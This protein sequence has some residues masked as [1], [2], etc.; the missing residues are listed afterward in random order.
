LFQITVIDKTYSKLID[1]PIDLLSLLKKLNILKNENY[2]LTNIIDMIHEA[3]PTVLISK[4]N[5][6]AEIKRYKISDHIQNLINTAREL[7]LDNNEKKLVE[8]FYDHA[9]R[10]GGLSNKQYF[11]LKE[12]IK[13][14]ASKSKEIINKIKS[15]PELKKRDHTIIEKLNKFNNLKITRHLLKIYRRVKDMI[16]PVRIADTD[17]GGVVRRHLTKEEFEQKKKILHELQ[18]KY[19]IE[20]PNNRFILEQKRKEEKVLAERKK[21]DEWLLKNPN[22]PSWAFTKVV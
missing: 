6:K 21:Y 14:P 11:M 8:S 5:R 19:V 10:T 13:C 15:I 4:L 20:N 3:Y 7:D 16:I 1:A 18:D 12:L 9:T 2:I 17:D 22:G